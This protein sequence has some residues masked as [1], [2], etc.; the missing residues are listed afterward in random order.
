[1]WKKVVFNSQVYKRSMRRVLALHIE[2]AE[3]DISISEERLKF[4]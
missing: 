4:M 3:E 1:M 2:D